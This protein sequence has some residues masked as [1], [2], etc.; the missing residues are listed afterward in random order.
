VDISERKQIEEERSR[1][2]GRAQEARAEA[3]EA[4]RMKDEFIAMVSHELRTPLNSIMGWARI[5]LAGNLDEQTRTRALETI[6]RNAALQAELIEDL[7]DLS[8]IITGKL[9]LEVRPVNLGSIIEAAIESIRPAADA[10]AIHLQVAL[11]PTVGL[12]SGDPNRLQQVAWNLLSNAVK[13]TPRGGRVEVRLERIETYV[14]V[15]VSDTGAGITQEFLPYV[16]DR[17]RQADTSSTRKQGGI[18][19]GLAI[20]RHLIEMHGGTIH[21]SSP[22]PGQG[23]TFTAKLPMIVP[24]FDSFAVER[25]GR[26]GATDEYLALFENVPSLEGLNLL[27]VDDEADAREL[28]TVVLRGCGAEVV[29]VASAAEALA[30][31]EQVKPDIIVSDIEM[32]NEDG[33]SLISRVRAR[34]AER[35]GRIQ[36]VALT[37]HARAEDRMRALLSGYDMHV[38]KPVEP[39][40]LVT[41]LVSLASRAAKS[42]IKKTQTAQRDAPESTD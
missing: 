27:V 29:V 5:L 9:R 22:G 10:K 30:A 17:F 1:L 13:F 11:D 7:M 19:L 15:T 33:Y 20:V 12:I 16:F 25:S 18:G 37:A 4:N 23:S 2:L 8:C 3:E 40:E 6:E 14:A 42:E 38:P 41:V 39:A 28:L 36:A 35:G 21:A 26:V 24:K 31:S 34:E 32:P